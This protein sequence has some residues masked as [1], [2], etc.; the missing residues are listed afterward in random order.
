MLNTLIQWFIRKKREALRQSYKRV[1]SVNEL[2]SD[3]W[4]KARYLGF[5]EKSSIYDSA[6][7][8]GDVKVGKNT[9][10]GPFV[11]L[12][13]SGGLKIGDNCSISAAVHIY[14]HDTVQWAVSG[15]VAPYE[16]AP[17]VIGN[18]CF[19]GPH[20]VIAKGVS[21]GNGCIIGA[22]SFINKSYPD[23]SKVVGR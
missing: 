4:E 16:Y 10:I 21:L 23:G 18:N 3:R 15:G 7:V 13:G 11:I 17:V 9:W 22:H 8:Y 5:G 6:L 19:I 14:S 1:L 12:D 20:T 2:F